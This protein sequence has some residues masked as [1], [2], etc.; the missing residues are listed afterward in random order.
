MRPP[1]PPPSSEVALA[2][3]PVALAR[4]LGVL[5]LA[6]EDGVL[7]V[8]AAAPVDP[9]D[10]E[11]LRVGAGAV[12]V[13]VRTVPGAAAWQL[14]TSGRRT[15]APALAPALAAPLAAAGPGPPDAVAV[16]DAVL[17]VAIGLDA[18]DVHLEGVPSGLR[19]R[20][21]RDGALRDLGVL[22]TEL[23]DQVVARTKVRAGLDVTERRTPQDGRL[24][25]AVPGG[26]VDVRVAT[27]PTRHGERVTLR[28]LP[29]GPATAV[30]RLGLPA[31]VVAAL[32]AAGSAADGLVVLCGPT[33]AGKTTTLHAVLADLA[34]GTRAVMT[35]EDPVERLVPGTT[36]TQ[37][38]PAA[39]L[40]FATGMRHLL[41]HDPDVLLVGE[42]RDAETAALAVEAARTGHLVLTTLHAV[43]APGA[44][45]RLDELGVAPE[46]AAGVL[47]LV[48]AQRLLTLPCPDCDAGGCRACDGTGARGRGA[49]AEALVWDAGLR[50]AVLAAPDA[51]RRRRAL[52]LACRPRLREVALAR[53]AAGG[54]RLAEARSATPDPDA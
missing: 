34:G 50:A 5:P 22:R 14:V 49:V 39:G 6:V 28:I 31:A 43:D 12:A 30:D 16:L 9:D 17:D 10:L 7:T 37:V 3:V 23:R 8:G 4:R 29:R 40:T 25:H 35:L 44:L 48:V 24:A 2:T 46:R 45:D 18:S 52:H 38:D 54:A 21:R 53:A 42:V 11:V 20:L 41:R 26:D 36:Q 15:L 13:V 51:G 47:R 33:G 32:R 1:P 27:L 19:I